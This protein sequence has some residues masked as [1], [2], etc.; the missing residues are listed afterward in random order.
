MA[1]IYIHIPFCKKACNYCNFHFS[2]NKQSMPQMIDAILTETR[3]QKDYLTGPVETIYFGGGTPSLLSEEQLNRMLNSLYKYFT[4]SDKAEITLEANPDDI[5]PAGLQEW[6]AAG[7]NRLSIGIQS[8]FE[9][10]LTWMGRA[11]NAEQA[12]RCITLAQAAGFNNLSIDLIYGGPTL[13]E[14][15]WIQNLQTAIQ[16]KVPHLSCYALTVEPKTILAKKIS[17]RQ[18]EEVDPEKQALHFNLLMESTGTAGY[19]HYEISNFA[20]PGFRSRHNS[21]YWSGSHYLG[22]GPAA[23]SFNGISRQWNIANNSLY[24]TSLYR[25]IVPAESETL[26]TEQ[27]MNEYIMTALRTSE[28]LNLK[29]LAAIGHKTIAAKVLKEAGHFI[30]QGTLVH[31]GDFLIITPK[32]RFYADGIAAELFQL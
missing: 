18:L 12:L 19:E 22:L 30:A 11:H 7:I 10:D 23:H 2:V 32:G 20:L 6:K 29:H 8:F 14:E 17:D 27:R 15:H 21:S 3:L 28:G 4:V 13:S 31:S 26:T 5:T 25:E 16:L 24:I 9:A 1:G